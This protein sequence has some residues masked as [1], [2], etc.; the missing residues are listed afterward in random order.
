MER[1][2]DSDNFEGKELLLMTF[3][4]RASLRR[5]HS[6]FISRE[7]EREREERRRSKLKGRMTEGRELTAS[8]LASLL[9]VLLLQSLTS[10]AVASCKDYGR[11][12]E[13]IIKKS[14]L[15]LSF[16]RILG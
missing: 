4:T 9:L 13:G 2:G 14:K 16:S 5:L 6:L 8:F 7:R 1:D 12:R 10:P 15:S 11:E 3:E